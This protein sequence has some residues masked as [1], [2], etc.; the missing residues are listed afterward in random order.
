MGKNAEYCFAKCLFKYCI[1]LQYMLV[2]E[3]IFKD[4]HFIVLPVVAKLNILVF[5]IIKCQNIEFK[6]LSRP[7]RVVKMITPRDRFETAVC[8][9]IPVFYT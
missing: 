3:Y 8:Q 4:Y 6:C 5:F 7:H 1:I 9:S 2:V